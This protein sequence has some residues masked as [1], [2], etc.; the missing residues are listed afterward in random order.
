MRTKHHPHGVD[1]TLSDSETAMQNGRS[2]GMPAMGVRER[3]AAARPMTYDGGNGYDGT[4]EREH[5]GVGYSKPAGVN[6][7]ANGRP[8]SK[9][10]TPAQNF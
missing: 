2:G 7:Y 6:G 5:A 9:Y 8:T 10:V 4:A 3:E 1:G